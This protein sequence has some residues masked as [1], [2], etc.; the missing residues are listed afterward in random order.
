[1]MANELATFQ[2]NI[3]DKL[4][5]DIGAMLPD[6]AL[7]ELVKRAVDETFFKE[8][9]IP[10][11]YGRDEIKSSW[12][13]SEIAKQ[14]KPVLD[15]IIRE[16]VKENEDVLKEAVSKFLDEQNLLLM[17]MQVMSTNTAQQFLMQCPNFKPAWAEFS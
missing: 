17:A 12:F 2:Q 1:M 8:R 16:W 6:A 5:A 14:A 9:R 11:S 15:T 13:V 3:I 4:R 7:D 10:Q